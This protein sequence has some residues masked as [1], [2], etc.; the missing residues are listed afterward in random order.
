MD[1]VARNILASM[2][3]NIFITSR[4]GSQIRSEV[5]FFKKI[6]EENIN[7]KE[8]FHGYINKINEAW[9]TILKENF[10]RLIL[11]YNDKYNMDL[12]LQL[13]KQKEMIKMADEYN[14]KRLFTELEDL[15]LTGSMSSLTKSFKTSGIS[16][17]RPRRR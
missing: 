8:V 3:Q 12:L 1:V 17:K 15:S 16:K 9:N 10:K 13:E 14:S 2:E 6:L 4:V 5:P 7:N 11:N